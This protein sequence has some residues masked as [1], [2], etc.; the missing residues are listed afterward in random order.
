MIP[1]DSAGNA[2]GRAFECAVAANV[3]Q[4]WEPIRANQSDQLLA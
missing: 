1:P 4:V 3:D 2:L